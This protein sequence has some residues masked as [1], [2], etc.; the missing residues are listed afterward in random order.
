M[1]S[2]VA[3][4]LLLFISASLFADED[5]YF[6]WVDDD[7]VLNFSQVAPREE[8]FEE[9]S[10]PQRFG[11]P[12]TR[13]EQE[14]S[15]S[16]AIDNRKALPSAASSLPGDISSESIAR[17]N[18]DVRARNCASARRT[19]DKLAGFK[20]IIIRGDDGFWREVS[21]DVK[22]QEILRAAAAIAENCETL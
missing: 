14:E 10:R 2:I 11:Y 7:G 4:I 6:M 9:I 8:V 21:D 12:Q 22:Q 16:E 18:R 3:S 17:I 19:L 15:Q 13:G 1:R 20:Q 5:S